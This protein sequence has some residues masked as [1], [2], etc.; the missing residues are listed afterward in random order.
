MESESE[1][2][3]WI[4]VGMVFCLL[5]S[6]PVRSDAVRCGAVRCGAVRCDGMGCEI[7]GENEVWV[8]P[9]SFFFFVLSKARWGCLFVYFFVFFRFFRGG[10][11]RR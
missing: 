1:G 8:S 7:A 4:R 5:S 11:W 9:F 10:E 2:F 6:W 3:G